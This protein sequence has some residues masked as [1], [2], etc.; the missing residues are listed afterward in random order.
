MKRLLPVALPLTGQEQVP[1]LT[2]F[3]RPGLSQ[4]FAGG[5]EAEEEPQG[6]AQEELDH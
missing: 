4:A 2:F 6:D 1:N 5:A 3:S